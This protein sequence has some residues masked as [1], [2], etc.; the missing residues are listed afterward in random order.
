VTLTQSS[1][2]HLSAG[3]ATQALEAFWRI[4]KQ[5]GVLFVTVPDTAAALSLLHEKGATSAI[6]HLSADG[7]LPVTPLDLL[8]GDQRSIR[9]GNR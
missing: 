1:L 9:E 4:L 3:Q 2:E 7:S 6:Y 5:G 8:F